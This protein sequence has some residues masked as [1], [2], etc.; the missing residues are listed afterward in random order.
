MRRIKKRQKYEQVLEILNLA[1]EYCGQVS[2]ERTDYYESEE[3]YAR[4]ISM[5]VAFEEKNSERP[6]EEI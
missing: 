6:L 3:E 4:H 2:N 1:A 5:Y